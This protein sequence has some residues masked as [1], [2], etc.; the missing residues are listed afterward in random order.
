[1]NYEELYRAERTKN[2]ELRHAM[3]MLTQRVEDMEVLLANYEARDKRQ[4]AKN[5]E[6]QKKFR[7]KSTE[8]EDKSQLN[9]KGANF[10]HMRKH[11]T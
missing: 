7:E 3:A 5:A 2:D 9:K 6:R 4:R 8:H 10:G 1:M 11:Q